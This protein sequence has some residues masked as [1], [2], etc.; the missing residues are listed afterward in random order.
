MDVSKRPQAGAQ[1]RGSS[2]CVPARNT[3][4]SPGRKGRCPGL[5]NGNGK[6]GSEDSEKAR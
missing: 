1:A 4:M 6:S 2:V 3:V 5:E